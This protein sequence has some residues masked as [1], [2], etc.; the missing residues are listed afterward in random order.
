METNREQ[1]IEDTMS[2]I[3]G[4][5][6]RSIS[7][8]LRNRLERIPKHI[9]VKELQ[10]PLRSMMLAAACILVL[11]TVNILSIKSAQN[12]QNEINETFYS[13]YFSHL[14]EI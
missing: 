6:Q 9:D 1:W 2:Q 8:N 12:K 14:N 5:A 11:I 4:I 10:I 7:S 3:D 13:S